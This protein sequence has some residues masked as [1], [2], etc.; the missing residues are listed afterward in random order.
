MRLALALASPVIALSSH[1]VRG[2]LARYA[3]HFGTGNPFARKN[4][5][6]HSFD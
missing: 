2:A 6:F 1:G 4:S 5:G 3:S